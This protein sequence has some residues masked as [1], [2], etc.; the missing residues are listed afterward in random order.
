METIQPPLGRSVVMQLHPHVLYRVYEARPAAGE[1]VLSISAIDEPRPLSATFCIQLVSAED[2]R[3]AEPLD[4]T[5]CVGPQWCSRAKEQQ[6]A[7]GIQM[8]LKWRLGVDAKE[9]EEVKHMC[10]SVQPG[11]CLVSQH[12][13]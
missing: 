11:S 4:S 2:G 5:H 12:V 1:D 10:K 13:V 9:K 6:E 3:N 8:Q 7:Q